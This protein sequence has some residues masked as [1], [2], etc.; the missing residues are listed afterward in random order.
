MIARISAKIKRDSAI[1]M[2]TFFATIG[3]NPRHLKA[4]EY[5]REGSSV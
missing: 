4:L 3:K 1:Y 2:G 5:R